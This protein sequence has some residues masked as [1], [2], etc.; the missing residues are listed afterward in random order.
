MLYRMKS[1]HIPMHYRKNHYSTKLW[2][3]L[4]KYL[5]RRG[6]TSHF[7]DVAKELKVPSSYLLRDDNWVSDE[8]LSEFMNQLERRI[9]EEKILEKTGYDTVSR[10]AMNPIEYALYSL[11]VFPYLFFNALVIHYSKYNLKNK[12]SILKRSPGK[13]IYKVVPVDGVPANENVCFNTIGILEGTSNFFK[14]NKISVTHSK[15][16]HHGGDFCE[17]E[18]NYKAYSYYCSKALSFFKLSGISLLSAWGTQSLVKAIDPITVSI[19]FTVVLVGCLT[20]LFWV[21]KNFLKMLKFIEQYNVQ[22]VEKNKELT[23]SLRQLD[24]RYHESNL[25]RGLAV[26]LV[27]TNVTKSVIEESLKDLQDRFGYARCLVM[28]LSADQKKMYTSHVTG[29]VDPDDLYSL[30]IAYPATQENPVLFANILSSGKA[31]LVEDVVSFKSQLRPDNKRVID[32]MGVTSI[33]VVPI[34]D[35]ESRY[36]LLVVG[37][38][39][40]D[41]RMNNEDLHLLENV[42]RL[43]AI[44]FQSAKSFEKEKTLRV[45]LQKYVPAVMTSGFD[46]IAHA[47]GGLAPKKAYVT[48]FFMDL[49]GFTSA[50][51]TM[52]PERTLEMLNI[53]L[54]MATYIVASF[55][56]ILDKIV[57]DAVVAYFPA[58]DGD[59]HDHAS[60]ALRAGI[61][62]LVQIE[63][64]QV[65][66]RERG[67]APVSLG[68]GIH[69]GEVILGMVGS[70]LKSDYTAIGDTMNLASR[71]ESM[72]KDYQNHSQS[73]NQ[74][75]IVVSNS[76]FSRANLNVSAHSIGEQSIRG[77][78]TKEAIYLIDR[79]QALVW[80]N[81]NSNLNM[82]KAS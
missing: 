80:W 3:G 53:Y 54:E 60:K 16:L 38:I 10:E 31:A 70:E 66:M 59:R 44:S 7:E 18:V 49:R 12:I 13:F 64:L 45:V 68:I 2:R 32:S 9:G 58:A 4:F 74:A 76:T 39:S 22:T 75:I 78:Q 62:I 8:F 47:N 23:D 43:L 63:N 55:G 65:K 51:E 29:F 17:F 40:H 57:A 48:A 5:E 71:L 37:S 33:V 14:F 69:T 50:C 35:E 25:L 27:S 34:M 11:F 41:R 79:D 15:C 72:S 21:S 81:S 36:G 56:G 61:E 77:R 67:F 26:K 42:S 1:D 73:S 28:M 82:K 24:K 30:E 20:T 19:F 6:L 52:A 46:V